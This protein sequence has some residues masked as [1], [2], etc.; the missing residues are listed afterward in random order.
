MI[1]QTL[2]DKVK[3]SPYQTYKRPEYLDCRTHGFICRISDDKAAK[4]PHERV[5][6]PVPIG[7]EI[8]IAKMLYEARISVPKPFS[9][10][11]VNVPYEPGYSKKG[12]IM[13]YIQGKNGDKIYKTPEY[14]FAKKL[15]KE[16]I[17]K[18]KDLGFF[19][20]DLIEDSSNWILTP[21]NRIILIDFADWLHPDVP[22]Y[23]DPE[24]VFAEAA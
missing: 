3:I 15:V 5:N 19:P 1:T 2:S 22:F 4:I 7:R 10:D 17:R 11:Y 8:M 24:T 18:I 14:Y 6:V 23:V 20:G 21:D 16:E 9:W 13:E 12:F